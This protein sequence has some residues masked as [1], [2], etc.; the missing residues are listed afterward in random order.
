MINI[1]LPE[2]A[3][4]ILNILAE[5]GFEAYAVGGCIRDSLLG[6]TPQD[7]DIC[8]SALPQ[9]VIG[10]FQNYPVL[11]TGLKHGT[12]TVFIEHGPFEVTTFR[13]EGKYSD[14][15]H[16]DKVEFVR[17]LQQDLARRDFTINAMA[18]N[19]NVGLVDC[20]NGLQDLQEKVL[21]C[22]GDPESRFLED[23]LRILRG[24]RFASTLDFK[25]EKNTAQAIHHKKD[26]LSNVA[27]ERIQ[28][29][30]NKLICGVGVK[31]IFHQF[32]DVLGVIIPEISTMLGFEQNNPH[33]IYDLW[34][35]TV[36]S[37]A[38]VPPETI[39]RLTM[40]FH[41]LGKPDCLTIDSKGIGHFY[42]HAKLSA[43]GT[44]EILHRL[45]Y[46]RSTISHVVTLVR[47][48]DLELLPSKKHLKR[49]L[50]KLGIV[51]C[52]QLLEVQKADSKAKHP[53]FQKKCLTKLREVEILLDEIIQGEE[54]FT[55][56]DLK[57]KGQ[58]ILE[59]GIKQGPEVGLVLEFLLK[60]VI[61]ERVENNKEQLLQLAKSFIEKR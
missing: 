33:H 8:T 34:T 30:F 46:D 61:E 42:G 53:D 24:L 11:E 28:V 37:V 39:L 22:V 2:G 9:Q 4:T 47:N 18:Y 54:C 52:K 35:H 1:K 16:P 36:E 45:K 44:K 6:E 23:G 58:D 21:R 10:A 50:N 19:P 49:V 60:Q 26:L 14:Y 12:V 51:S 48:H 29:E 27:V 31:G 41:D 25:L 7:W 32:A 56:K 57:V 59:I 17:D 43:E 5:Q 38:Q 15:R 40:L 20:F 13:V 3:R 55:L